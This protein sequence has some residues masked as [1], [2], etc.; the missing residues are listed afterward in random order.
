VKSENGTYYPKSC[1][2]G[3]QSKCYQAD[4][5][6]CQAEDVEPAS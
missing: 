5:D 2:A 6:A 4:D 3:E 1:G